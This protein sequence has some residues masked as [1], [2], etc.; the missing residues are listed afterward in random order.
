MF[1]INGPLLFE[2]LSFFFKLYPP[3]YE[4]HS[5]F[6]PFPVPNI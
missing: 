6:Q 3:N 4:F 5:K 1:I 2:L